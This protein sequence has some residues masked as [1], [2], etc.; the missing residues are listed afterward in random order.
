MTDTREAP[1]REGLPSLPAD[2]VLPVDKPEGPTSHDVV[3]AVRRALGRRRVGHTGTL[4]PFAS[5]LLLVCVGKTT[6]LAEYLSGLDKTYEAVA[7]VGETTDTLDREGE[8][9][10]VRDGWAEL[11]RAQ[12]EAALARFEGRIDQVPPA[13][14]AKKVRGEA[15]HRRARRGETVLLAPASV[16]VHELELT[17][18]ELPLVGF[19]MRCSSGTYVRALAR[20]VGAELGVGAHLVALR[21]TAIGTFGVEGALPVDRLEDGAALAAA[22]IE[23]LEALAHLPRLVADDAEAA[24]LSQ[25]RP[26]EGVDESLDGLVAVAHDGAL[27]AVGESAGGVLRP[28]KVFGA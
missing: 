20:D 2:F 28:R 25:G 8:V 7:R 3:G 6:R 23:P 21:R 26:L 13:F 15:A 18:L 1:P 19:R 24:L 10:E 14:S 22:A 9:V 5:G 16:A 4:D 12:I 17:S 27:L 11:D